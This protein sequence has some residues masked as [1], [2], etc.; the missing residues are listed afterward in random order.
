[1]AIK[2]S[3]CVNRS[4]AASAVLGEPGGGGGRGVHLLLAVQNESKPI[5]WLDAFIG[6]ARRRISF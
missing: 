5:I 2:A 1:M 6:A 3:T 4:A